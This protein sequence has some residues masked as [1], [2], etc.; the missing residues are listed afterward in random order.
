MTPINTNV[1]KDPL[2]LIKIKPDVT[3]AQMYKDEVM[4]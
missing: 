1:L 3:Q 2:L 4:F